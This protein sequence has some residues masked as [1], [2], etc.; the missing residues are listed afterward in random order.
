ML[1]DEQHWDPRDYVTDVCIYWSL[2]RS[3]S[4]VAR[5]GWPKDLGISQN[6]HLAPGISNVCSKIYWLEAVCTTDGNGCL[7]ELTCSLM[8]A[9]V[10]MRYFV[11]SFPSFRC[12]RE[13]AEWDSHL[14]P[15]D[16][17]H[18][19]QFSSPNAGITT[20]TAWPT[21]THCRPWWVPGALMCLKGVSSPLPASFMPQIWLSHFSQAFWVHCTFS[22][23][24]HSCVSALKRSTILT[25][26]FCWQSPDQLYA[27]SG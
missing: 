9:T 26:S 18:S 4:R 16:T 22:C 1:Q 12:S 20:T 7:P 15:P 5:H 11:N 23:F 21:S 24:L 2:T 8:Y 17:H 25:C 14:F 6:L 27:L 10:H 19:T 3:I 13:I